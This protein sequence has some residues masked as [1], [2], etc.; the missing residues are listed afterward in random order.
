[1]TDVRVADRPAAG[2]DEITRSIGVPLSTLIRLLEDRDGGIRVSL[3]IEGDLASPDVNY[4]RAIWSLLPRVVRAFFRSPVGFVSSA[5]S[6]AQAAQ[7]DRVAPSAAP[8]V[9]ADTAA[10]GAA[11]A[12]S[13]VAA[14]GLPRPD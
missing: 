13:A 2:A 5:T 14:D 11:P 7:S 4:R 6:L 9:R 8:P 12:A 1:M 10:L 3:P